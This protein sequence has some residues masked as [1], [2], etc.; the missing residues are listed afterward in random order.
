MTD[1]NHMPFCTCK[2]IIYY[3]KTQIESGYCNN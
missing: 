1:G 3:I 2:K